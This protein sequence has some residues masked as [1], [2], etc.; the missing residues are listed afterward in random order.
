MCGPGTKTT[1]SALQ[2]FHLLS[3]ALLTSTNGC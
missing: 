2:R 1:T 3:E